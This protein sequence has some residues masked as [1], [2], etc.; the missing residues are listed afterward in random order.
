MVCARVTLRLCA[1]PCLFRMEAKSGKNKGN[2]QVQRFDTVNTN[3]LMDGR[4]FVFLQRAFI[5]SP[6]IPRDL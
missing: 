3:R 1:L 5:P 4:C 2:V 6:L